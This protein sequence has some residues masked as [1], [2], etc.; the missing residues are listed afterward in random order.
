MIYLMK[1][2][3]MSLPVLAMCSFALSMSA[4]PGPVNLLILSNALSQGWRHTLPL[5]SG[6][7]L[8]FIALL[9]LL[10]VG[11]QALSP[12]PAHMLQGMSYLALLY[13]VYL[14]AKIACAK[15]ESQQSSAMPAGFV[16]GALMQILN[17]KAWLACLAGIS[18]F[19]EAEKPMQIWLFIAIY[20]VLCY[21]A[22]ASWAY[23][24]AQAGRFLREPRSLRQLNF[25]LSGLLLVSAFFNLLPR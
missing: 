16:Y 3:L 5:V 17:P 8:G 18:L 19:A 1:V 4:S 6:A 21:L 20:F 11:L 9:S 2:Q 12:L 13:T 22:L 15:V 14:A 25:I 24:G 10:A 23:A 7:T